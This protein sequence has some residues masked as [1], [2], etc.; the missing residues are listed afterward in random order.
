MDQ[1]SIEK[2]IEMLEKSQE[3]FKTK[4][5]MLQDSLLNDE[6]MVALEDKMKDA[7]TRYVAQKNALLNEPDNRKLQADLK[8]LAQEIKDTKQLLGDELLAYFM[9][10]NTLEFQDASGQ[11]RRFAVSAHFVRN[12]E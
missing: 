8:D 11:K 6:E 7:K 10:N 2:R 5:Q 9:K 4:K 1:A 12:K 3:E